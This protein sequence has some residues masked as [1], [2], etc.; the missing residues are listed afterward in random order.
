[1]RPAWCAV[2][3]VFLLPWSGLAEENARLDAALGANFTV[4][5]GVELYV[6][7]TLSQGI[8]SFFAH[9]GYQGERLRWSLSETLNFG[10]DRVGLGLNFQEGLVLQLQA[11]RQRPDFQLDLQGSLSFQEGWTWTLKSLWKP[12]G[13]G[14]SLEGQ[15]Q[16]LE[17][18]A[19]TWSQKFHWES[20]SLTLDGQIDPSG[21][22]P[23]QFSAQHSFNEMTFGL[24]GQLDLLADDSQLLDAALSLSRSLGE[25]DADVSLQF[26]PSGWQE[27]KV[28]GTRKFGLG[29]N[30][31]G[32]SLSFSPEGWQ[33]LSV[34]GLLMPTGTG[35]LW[36]GRLGVGPEGFS[37]LLLTGNVNRSG[38]KLGGTVTGSPALWLLDLSG[39]VQL[40]LFQLSGKLSWMSQ[41]GL[42][43]GGLR[44]GRSFEF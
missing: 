1:M 14:L 31:L 3:V 25:F 16:V 40:A 27:L 23:L 24:S 12:P 10:E 35:D 5:S 13:F 34:D 41:S 32:G 39:N 21:W 2:L 28:G 15:A 11:S 20:E 26:T 42:R 4:G 37:S 43:Q 22:K 8:W 29:A 38:L 17:G 19:A 36:Q 7:A 44:A 6:E 9:A 18:K 30:H 33:D